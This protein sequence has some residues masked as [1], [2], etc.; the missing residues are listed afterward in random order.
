MTSQRTSGLAVA[1]LVLGILSL[2][3]AAVC[4]APIAAVICGHLAL[5]QI[6]RAAGQVGGRGLAIAGLVTGYL[7]LVAG[8]VVLLFFLGI[9]RLGANMEASQKQRDAQQQAQDAQRARAAVGDL[10]QFSG[11]YDYGE[12]QIRVYNEGDVLRTS[13]PDVECEMRPL[14]RDLFVFQRCTKPTS[15]RLQFNRNA[16]GE[17]IGMTVR[18]YDLSNKFCRKIR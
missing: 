10:N 9:A 2:F 5:G 13:S 1:S 7:A 15:A 8:V 6:K 3:G 17:I 4:G 12:Y 16:A 11:M 14:D 18:R